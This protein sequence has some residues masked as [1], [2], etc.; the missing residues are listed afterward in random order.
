MGL[1]GHCYQHPELP[2]SKVVLWTP[3]HGRPSR[4]CPIMTMVDVLM[5]DTGTA[6]PKELAKCMMDQT[7][8]QCW[9]HVRLWMTWWRINNSKMFPKIYSLY[10]GFKWKL[11][12]NKTMFVHV[13]F[14]LQLTTVDWNNGLKDYTYWLPQSNITVLHTTEH[15]H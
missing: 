7:D 13:S 9:R 12:R 11:S 3:T 6:S 4:G 10:I 15:F 2:A 14:Q 1:A 5:Q 8:W